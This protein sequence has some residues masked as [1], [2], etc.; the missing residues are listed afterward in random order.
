MLEFISPFLAFISTYRYKPGKI[1]GIGG[2]LKSEI[3]ICLFLF[4]ESRIS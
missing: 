2:H 3:S 4:T 1:N